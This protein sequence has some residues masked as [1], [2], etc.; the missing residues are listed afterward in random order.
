[1]SRRMA[2]AGGVLMALAAMGS[3]LAG[4]GGDAADPATAPTPTT[5]ATVTAEPVAG[6]CAAP[7]ADNL[8]KADFAFDGTVT[9]VADDAVTLTVDHWYAG[10]E[11]D[12]VEVQAPS[13]D[14]AGLLQVVEFKKG[15]RFL[16][17]GHGSAV[18]PCGLSGAYSDDLADL[19]QQAFGA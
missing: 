4:C 9:A 15:G 1:M 2:R 6:R 12:V 17:A 19:Y 10:E 3:V 13:A 8:A 11:A 18:L 5:T 7:S 16:V 14:L